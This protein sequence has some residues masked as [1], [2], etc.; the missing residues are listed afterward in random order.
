MTED[1]R[2]RVIARRMANDIERFR[3]DGAGLHRISSSL[4]ANLG[5]LE[6]VGADH[7]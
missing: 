5:L 6:Q 7:E 3:G 1:D 4:K 2:I